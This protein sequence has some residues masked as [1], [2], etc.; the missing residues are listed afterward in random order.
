MMRRCAKGSWFEDKTHR[1]FI[2]YNGRV[3]QDFPNGGHGKFEV[4]LGIVRNVVR[5]F[6]LDEAC[7]KKVVPG[8]PL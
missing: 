3:Y 6:G 1:Y 5:F 8:L 2:H 4:K 7:A